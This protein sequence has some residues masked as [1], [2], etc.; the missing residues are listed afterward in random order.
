MNRTIVLSLVA[1]ALGSAPALAVSFSRADRNGDGVVTYDE[2]ERAF[3]RLNEK[4]I[5]KADKNDNGTIEK[6][7]MP[8]LNYFDRFVNE[9]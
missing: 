4:F 9:D 5:A 2:A 7:E 6:S 8:S 3:P 1:L